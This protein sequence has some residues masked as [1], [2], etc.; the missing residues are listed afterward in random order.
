MNII[1]I[2][3]SHCSLEKDVQLLIEAINSAVLT[4]DYV[5]VSHS[6][7]LSQSLIDKMEASLHDDSLFFT[8]NKE[9]KISQ[10]DH[11]NLCMKHIERTLLSNEEFTLYEYVVVLLD[12]HD[13]LLPNT[14]SE[15][16]KYMNEGY[17]A[18]IGSQ[19]KFILS[20]RD[21]DV[22]DNGNSG[23]N[24]WVN[25]ETLERLTLEGVKINKEDNNRKKMDYYE[26]YHIL[27]DKR[28]SNKEL[29]KKY[30]DL[31][32]NQCIDF[33]Y[34]MTNVYT[35][36]EK[37]HPNRMLPLEEEKQLFKDCNKL[38]LTDNEFSG[39]W[40]SLYILDS[41][42]KLTNDKR[43]LKK[44]V[45]KEENLRADLPSQNDEEEP[46]SAIGTPYEDVY[47]TDVYLS[48][49]DIAQNERDAYVFFRENTEDVVPL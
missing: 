3:P 46:D 40:C 43:L 36:D 20:L 44:N 19:Y 23:A 26:K 33:L 45:V 10:F 22:I 25:K 14:R 38:F 37:K 47:F 13:M 34:E 7:I 17:E 30:G 9:V 42:F 49:F 6:G 48:I 27:N 12:Y 4:T 29:Y 5:Y 2:I 15:I 16:Y 24:G 28:K 39:T 32:A 11:I 35:E 8:K 1:C 31:C 18:A 21:N 41:Y